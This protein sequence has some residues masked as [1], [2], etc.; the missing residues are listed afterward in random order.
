MDFIREII[1]IT[2]ISYG[3]RKA[4]AR[5]LTHQPRFPRLY[6][7]NDETI[8]KGVLFLFAAHFP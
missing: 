7:D 4:A 1:F 8:S 5:I 3:K 6:Q 2:G